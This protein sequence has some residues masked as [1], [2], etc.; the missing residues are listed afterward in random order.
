MYGKD[1]A[2]SPPYTHLILY[3]YI[4][5]HKH[6]I[7]CINTIHKHTHTYIPLSLP[8]LHYCVTTISNGPV[9][10]T[11]IA[12]ILSQTADEGLTF[13]QSHIS[14]YVFNIYTQT[15]THISQR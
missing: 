8:H 11:E 1:S 6:T 15:H 14:L 4:Y 12:I 10:S 7:T 9:W 5:A 13:V 3:V 2:S